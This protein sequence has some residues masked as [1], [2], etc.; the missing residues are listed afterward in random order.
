MY[1][2]NCSTL[3]ERMSKGAEETRKISDKQN[4][5]RKGRRTIDHISTLTS[6]IESRKLLKQSTYV[7]FVDFRKAYDTINRALLWIKLV[8]IGLNGKYF[9]P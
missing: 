8:N 4:G 5:L 1:K 7:C 9:I 3:N 2:A 6:I